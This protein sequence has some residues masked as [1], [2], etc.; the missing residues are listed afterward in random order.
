M[1][2]L[3]SAAPG[4]Y[5]DGHG[6]IRYFD[7]SAWTHHTQDTVTTPA[8]NPYA[9]EAAEPVAAEEKGPFYRQG[10]FLVDVAFLAA[11]AALIAYAAAT[12]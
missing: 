6:A 2:A 9:E 5:P 12:A 4:W 11:M 7:G 8:A 3:T 1:T 10:W